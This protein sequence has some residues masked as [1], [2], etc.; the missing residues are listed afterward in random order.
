MIKIQEGKNSNAKTF[1][2]TFYEVQYSI[3]YGWEKSSIIYSVPNSEFFTKS[4]RSD[5]RLGAV[6][7]EL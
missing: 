3:W 7:V 6:T 2:Y 5:P 1:I 4:I